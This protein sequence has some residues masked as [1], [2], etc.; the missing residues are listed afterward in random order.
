MNIAPK[1][2]EFDIVFQSVLTARNAALAKAEEAR[3]KKNTITVDA[4]EYFAR[5]L[6]A[7][8]DAM[9]EEQGSN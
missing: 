5:E 9:S 6:T 2:R 7:V 8:L 3:K 4:Q 1:T